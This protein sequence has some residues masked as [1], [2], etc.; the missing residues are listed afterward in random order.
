MQNIEDKEDYQAIIQK[1]LYKIDQRDKTKVDFQALLG[2]ITNCANV[3][4]RNI[5]HHVCLE[6]QT[7][8]EKRLDVLFIGIKSRS[9]KVLINEYK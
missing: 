1:L 3:I 6:L 2:G 5:K 7:E 9:N 4:G 8:H